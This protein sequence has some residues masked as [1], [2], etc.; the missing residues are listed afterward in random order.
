M[1][2]FFLSCREGR[3]FLLLFFFF[4]LINLFYSQSQGWN[5]V[6]AKGDCGPPNLKKKLNSRYVFK[7]LGNKPKKNYIYPLKKIIFAPLDFES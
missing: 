4:L 3:G 6:Q 7:I 1:S 2:I 5:H